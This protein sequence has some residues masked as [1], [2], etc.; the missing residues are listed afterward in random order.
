MAAVT[1]PML[2]RILE[3]TMGTQSTM[4]VLLN[5]VG[6]VTLTSSMSTIGSTVDAGRALGG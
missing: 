3:G 6:E 1:G 5:G 2:G 4:T